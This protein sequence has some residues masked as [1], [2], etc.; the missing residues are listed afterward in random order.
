MNSFLHRMLSAA[1]RARF[2]R[3]IAKRHPLVSGSVTVAR[4][5]LY[6]LPTGYGYF[7]VAT[8]LVLF[9]WSINYSN[10]MGFVLTFLLGAVALNA[11]WRCHEN[12]HR[13]EIHALEA[14]P[15]FA[16]EHARFVYRLN[17]ASPESRY[18]IALQASEGE[19]RYADVPAQASALAHV[20]VAAPQRGW[21]KPGRLRV[22]TPFPLGLFGAWTWA[23]FDQAC[24]I[25]PKPAGTPALPP[26]GDI[27]AD[28]HTLASATAGR[29]DY[30]GLRAYV[31]GDSARH[32]AWKASARADT[33]LVKHYAG[34][35][36]PE[37]WLDWRQLPAQ[38]TE[39]RLAQLCLWVL[40]A[41]E[42]GYDYGLRLPGTQF[43]PSRGAQHRA[44][45][46][47]A[48]ALFEYA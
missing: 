5:R 48:L 47:R 36:L 30:A 13:L 22:S 31:P 20:E 21:L 6:I 10:S 16:G 7:F 8:L 40:K 44:R 25:Y 34:Q 11:M 1:L 26:T 3:W 17:N 29:D 33:L 14:A 32:V 23:Q 39:A 18:S 19:T 2:D 9:L 24:L 41:E 46:L 38:S 43:A 28:G 4:E 12:L 35:A 37:I 45:C 15:V 27:D 42:A